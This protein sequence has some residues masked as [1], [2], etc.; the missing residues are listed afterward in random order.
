MK[1][2]DESET[3]V[4]EIESDGL[5][6]HFIDGLVDTIITVWWRRTVSQVGGGALCG[7]VMG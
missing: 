1:E 3:I 6:L 4:R 5:E 2:S 7:G